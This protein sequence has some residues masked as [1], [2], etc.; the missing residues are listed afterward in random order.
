MVKTFLERLKWQHILTLIILCGV[1][2]IFN[3]VIFGNISET[4]KSFATSIVEVLKNGFLILIGFWFGNAV[5]QNEL[6]KE[7]AAGTTTADITATVTT[8]PSPN[9][10]PSSTNDQLPQDGNN[11][12]QP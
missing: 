5:K 4:G 10:P 7:Q 2:K 6:K 1:F 8:S 9:T 12:S 11:I 3:G